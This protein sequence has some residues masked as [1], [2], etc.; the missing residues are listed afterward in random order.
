MEAAQATDGATAAAA[1][2]MR[3][4]RLLPTSP[5]L[6]EDSEAKV[7]SG[8][9]GDVIKL[10]G[11]V[12]GVVSPPGGQSSTEDPVSETSRLSQSQPVIAVLSF[13]LP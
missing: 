9:D 7:W 2:R 3:I 4:S 8:S 12:T 5:R 10:E 1:T 11:L 13:F 6:P